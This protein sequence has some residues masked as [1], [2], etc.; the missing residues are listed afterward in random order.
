MAQLS[1]DC[2]YAQIVLKFSQALAAHEFDVAY[3][4]LTTATRGVMSKDDLVDDYTRMIAYGD[5][6]ANLCEV[7]IVDDSMPNMGNHD[8]A[9]VYVA[10]CGSGFSE[11]VTVMVVD[12]EGKKAIRIIE[13]GRP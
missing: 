13:W 1:N 2:S 12:D 5:G 9:W 7:M 11:A 8:L 6:P 4:M 3:E 10:I